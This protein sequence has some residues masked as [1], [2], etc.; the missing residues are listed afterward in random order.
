[1]NGTMIDDMKYHEDAWYRILNEEL[2]KKMNRQE[3]K[4]Q[5]F[6]KNEELFDRVFGKGKFSESEKK[7]WSLKKEKEYQAA[8][9]PYLSLLPGLQE[10]FAA[11]K[12]AGIKMAIGTAASPF[13]VDFVLNNLPIKQFFDVVLNADDVETSK[14]DPEIF[15]KCAKKLEIDPKDCLVFEDA[16]NGVLAAQNAGMDAVAILSYNRRGDFE[17][18][19][20]VQMT[21]S[22][23]NDPQLKQLT[24]K[25]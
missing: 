9:K 14:P 11:A 16:P 12:D 17:K 13:N 10:F 8:Y 7:E 6:G 3:V 20:N 18:Y 24:G 5:M 25:K 2:G 15:L 22:D 4:E 23:Y 1:M 21:V 19:G